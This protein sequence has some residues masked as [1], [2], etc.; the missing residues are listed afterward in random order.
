[1]GVRHLPRAWKSFAKRFLTHGGLLPALSHLSKRGVAIL[2]YHSVQPE[3]GRYE[4][5]IGSGIIHSCKVFQ[6][7][8]EIVARHYVPVTLDDI[9]KFLLG[10]TAPP[11][12]SV[13]VTFDD[14]YADNYEFALPVL[15]R[16]GV[17][18]AFYVAV[19][20]I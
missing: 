17:P 1:M 16:A 20:S 11:R 18:A 19:G 12:R 5:S 7:Q 2:R 13:A 4:Y 6:E 15:A 10:E 3:P 14:G 9:L 8:M